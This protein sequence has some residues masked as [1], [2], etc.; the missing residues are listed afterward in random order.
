MWTLW[1]DKLLLTMTNF[2]VFVPVV[3]SASW[4]D[5]SPLILSALL[6]LIHHSTEVRYYQPA[7]LQSTPLQR[8][9]FLFGDQLGAVQALLFI[10]K[11]AL[12]KNELFSVVVAFGSMLL[13]EAVM[14]I[15]PD[16][17]GIKLRTLLHCIWH[18][19]AL[20][21]LPLLSLTKY[22]HSPNFYQSFSGL[23]VK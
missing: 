8:R 22:K 17:I 19:Y 16:A 14:Y 21:Y 4:I 12:L 15:F 9:W 6:S 7:L 18:G 5:V 3:Y 2:F 23:L 11:Y 13:S 20:G 10:G 1:V